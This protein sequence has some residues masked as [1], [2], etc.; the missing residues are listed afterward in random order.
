M[1][2][3]KVGVEPLVVTGEAL[4]LSLSPAMLTRLAQQ[5]S[6]GRPRKRCY[7]QCQQVAQVLMAMCALNTLRYLG[8]Q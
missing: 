6:C 8:L 2:F 3:F 1:Q 4:Q 5:P 7:F